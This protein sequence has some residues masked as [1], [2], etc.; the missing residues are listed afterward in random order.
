MVELQFDMVL[1]FFNIVFI[2]GLFYS[3]L[4]ITR[5]LNT[6]TTLGNEAIKIVLFMIKERSS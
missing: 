4:L 1:P 2:G 6:K 5:C 3:F